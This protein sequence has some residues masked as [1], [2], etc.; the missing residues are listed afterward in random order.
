[1]DHRQG[2]GAGGAMPRLSLGIGHRAVAEGPAG[3]RVNAEALR[4]GTT[5]GSGAVFEAPAL[6]S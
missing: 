6:V 2:R 5:T 1:M 3:H 4:N